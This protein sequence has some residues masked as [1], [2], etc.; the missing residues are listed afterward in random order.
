LTRRARLPERA[1]MPARCRDTLHRSSPT[2][3][4]YRASV[5]VGSS[6]TSASSLPS[7]APEPANKRSQ[8]TKTIHHPVN[9]VFHTRPHR[10]IKS[11]ENNTEN[12]KKHLRNA[13]TNDKNIYLRRCI[14]LWPY[15]QWRIPKCSVS[16]DIW[17]VRRSLTIRVSCFQVWHDHPT[18]A[19]S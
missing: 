14:E 13:A 2:P 5:A 1:R 3:S 7:A 16:R 15:A 18:S 8:K 10:E 4:P 6:D 17:E 11:A 12:P 19:M 9:L